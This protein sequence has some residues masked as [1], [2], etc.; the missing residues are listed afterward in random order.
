MFRKQCMDLLEGKEGQ[1]AKFRELK[2][3]YE[4]VP[5]IQVMNSDN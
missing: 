2:K 4:Q 1:E 5:A 3:A